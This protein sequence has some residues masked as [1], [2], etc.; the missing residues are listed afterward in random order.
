MTA[1]KSR[2]LEQKSDVV[3]CY[4]RNKETSDTV[5]DIR[6]QEYTLR[7]ICNISEK[8]KNLGVQKLLH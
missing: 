7:N 4:A 1:G 2:A 3:R 6:I 5:P 8:K